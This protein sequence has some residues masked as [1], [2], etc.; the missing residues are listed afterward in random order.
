MQLAIHGQWSGR[1]VKEVSTLIMI[2]LTVQL[3]AMNASSQWSS[4]MRAQPTFSCTHQRCS[5]GH[6]G[7]LPHTS[8]IVD[9]DVLSTP[10]QLVDLPLTRSRVYLEAACNVHTSYNISAH[11]SPSSPPFHPELPNS[12][13]SSH[14]LPSSR[15]QADSLTQPGE[16]EPGGV[17]THSR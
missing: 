3:D 13:S 7:I 2:R 9:S 4:A 11:D 15:F 1:F 10:N 14:Q 12:A 16:T 8:C 17:I 5:S 6:Q